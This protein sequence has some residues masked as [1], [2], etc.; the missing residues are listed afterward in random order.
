MRTFEIVDLSI[1]PI[2]REENIIYEKGFFGQQIQAERAIAYEIV[3]QYVD[4]IV[5]PSLWFELWFNRGLKLF[6]T[7]NILNKVIISHLLALATRH[8]VHRKSG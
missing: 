8:F 1:N 5:R 4:T 3:R 7:Y 2:F 6:L